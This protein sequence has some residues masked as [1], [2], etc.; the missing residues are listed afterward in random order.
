[1]KRLEHIGIAV[2]NLEQSSRLFTKLLGQEPY[3][4]E[5]VESEG[6]KTSFFMVGDVKIELLEGTRSDSAIARFVESRGEGLHHLA[7]HTDDIPAAKSRLEPEGFVFTREKPFDGADNKQVIFIH[8][9][10][11]NGVLVE[12]CQDRA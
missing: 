2:R 3:K 8:P 6:V 5:E 9:K 1:M 12:L 11:A 7:F 4:T 10:T